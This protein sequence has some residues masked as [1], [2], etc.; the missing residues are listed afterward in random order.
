MGFWEEIAVEH[1]G[2]PLPKS[3]G[4][5]PTVILAA[6]RGLRLHNDSQGVPKPL[7]SL[8]GS[9]LLERAVL[10]CREAGITECYVIVG[11]RNDLLIPYIQ[12]LA[13]RHG[14]SLHAVENPHWQEGNGVSVLA[15]APYVRGAFLLLMCDHLFDPE[16][17]RLLTTAAGS[18]EMTFLAVDRHPERL[19]DLAEAT[20]VQLN[21]QKIAAIG[22]EIAPFDAVDTGLFLCQQELFTALESARA[23]GDG[24]LTGGVRRMIAADKMCAVDIGER[25]WFDVDTPADVQQVTRLLLAAV[26]SSDEIVPGGRRLGRDR[27]KGHNQRQH[28][29]CGNK[30][31]ADSKRGKHSQAEN[32]RV[33]GDHETAKT[34]HRG[35]G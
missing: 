24:T 6:G 9:T 20:K 35:Q 32:S 7:M 31:E 16:I 12:A 1:K 14:V 10:S 26:A 15:A 4:A 25:F 21:G 13:Q 27:R 22:K 2:V 33:S 18:S 11:Y 28:H 5:L 29:E 8:L 17:L 30:T 23:T 34:N 3:Q 19:F